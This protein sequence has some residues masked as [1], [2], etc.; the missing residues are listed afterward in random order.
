MERKVLYTD[1]ALND[2]QRIAAWSWQQYPETSERFLTALLNHID[3][4][5]QFPLMGAPVKGHIG[6]RRLLHTP[7]HVYYR[8]TEATQTV[9]LLHVWHRSRIEPTI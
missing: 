4:L 2:L 9:E 6:V 7:F 3:L 8:F 5:A 1:E